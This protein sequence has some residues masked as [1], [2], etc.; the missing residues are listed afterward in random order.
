MNDEQVLAS[1]TSKLDAAADDLSNMTRADLTGLEAWLLRRIVQQRDYL[2]D[3]MQPG[4]AA[5]I[6]RR[7]ADNDALRARIAVLEAAL[8]PIVETDGCNA[9]YRE[10]C[11][12]CFRAIYGDPEK[13]APDC[14]VRAER[15]RR[16]IAH[17]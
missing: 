17:G 7:D 10:T 3:R 16:E 12:F 9:T 11:Q 5:A 13:H 1:I 8:A 15:G 6:D 14:F 4:L 2:R